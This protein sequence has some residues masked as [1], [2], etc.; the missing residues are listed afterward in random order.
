MPGPSG[1][2]TRIRRPVVLTVLHGALGVP[3]QVSVTVAHA[4]AFT[5]GYI[6]NRT[7]N[8]RSHAAVGSQAVR[9]AGVV[10]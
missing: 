1:F 3:L 5:L 10:W 6:L 8:F 9:Y 2:A 4:C 7:L